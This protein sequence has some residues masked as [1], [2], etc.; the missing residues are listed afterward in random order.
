MACPRLIRL[1]TF[2]VELI[3]ELTNPKH[4][5]HCSWDHLT[6][7]CTT[8]ILETDTKWWFIS[9]EEYGSIDLFVT[10]S[11]TVWKV[12]FLIPFFL[13]LFFFFSIMLSS[14]S[15]QETPQSQNPRI[16]ITNPSAIPDRENA[17]VAHQATP[18]HPLTW[19]PVLTPNST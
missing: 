4:S 11:S 10:I 15:L 5:L 17:D 8:T 3:R 19:F 12:F 2:D 16:D 14:S 18:I 7:A 13:F 1:S 6:A 9:Y